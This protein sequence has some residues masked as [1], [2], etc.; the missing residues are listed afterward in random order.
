MLKRIQEFKFIGKLKV[1]E[2]QFRGQFIMAR[3]FDFIL[4]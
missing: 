1:I 4:T 2:S 3:S